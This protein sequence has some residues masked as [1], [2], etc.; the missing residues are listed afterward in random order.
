MGGHKGERREGQAGMQMT[1]RFAATKPSRKIGSRRKVAGTAKTGGVNGVVEVTGMG[2]ENAMP[3]GGE[4]KW[5]I[6]TY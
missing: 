4:G 1:H 3:G 6:C 2:N 5:K